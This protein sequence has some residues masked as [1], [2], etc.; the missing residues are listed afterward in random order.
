M[1][2]KIL[3]ID[4]QLF[5]I[6]NG[7]LQCLFLDTWMPIVTDIDNWVWLLVLGFT[8]LF[9]FG[10][11]RGKWACIITLVAVLIADNFNSYILKEWFGRIRPNVA[12]D[13]VRFFGRT[14][15]KVPSPAF[16]SGH[17]TNVFTMAMVLSWYNPRVS[18][19]WFLGAFIVG[20]SRVY[21]GV[22]YP[23]DIISGAFFGIVWALCIIW[24]AKHI[25]IWLEKKRIFKKELIK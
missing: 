3:E 18:P 22:H 5:H 16:P 2:Q 23:L 21:V 4:H 12:L 17:A 24:C 13:T 6:I 8:G 9:I 14:S 1:L 20:Y 25:E 10:G 7:K 11:R 15:A 19:I